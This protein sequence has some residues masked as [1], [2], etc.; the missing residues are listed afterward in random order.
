MIISGRILGSLKV[1]SKLSQSC[2]ITAGFICSS[3]A[4]NHARISPEHS[5]DRVFLDKYG[6]KHVAGSLSW[7]IM[8]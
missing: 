4:R 2:P 7:N 1:A 5:P 8:N 6:I 3:K